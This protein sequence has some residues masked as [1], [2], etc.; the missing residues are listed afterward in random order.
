MEDATPAGSPA[1]SKG[2]RRRTLPTVRLISFLPPG[3]A[4]RTCDAWPCSCGSQ[5]VFVFTAAPST[6]PTEMRSV[7]PCVG[8]LLVNVR[9]LHSTLS[10]IV[11]FAHLRLSHTLTR[12]NL[13][14]EYPATL[15]R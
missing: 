5:C 6:L 4:M 3:H 14:P 1:G 15:Q 12:R 8:W 11:N 7:F 2:R 13:G 9:T 10:R